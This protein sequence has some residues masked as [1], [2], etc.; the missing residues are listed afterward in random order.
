[1]NKLKFH[2]DALLKMDMAFFKISHSISVSFSFFS[3]SRIFL[4]CSVNPSFPLSV[5][6]HSC[7][8]PPVKLCNCSLTE[9]PLFYSKINNNF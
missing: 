8:F 6:E 7:Y 9:C 4:S 1:M 2:F 5:F 3:S